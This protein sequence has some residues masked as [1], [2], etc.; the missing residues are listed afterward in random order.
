MADNKGVAAKPRVVAEKKVYVLINA[1]NVKA[2]DILS[3]VTNPG[4]GMKKMDELQKA[5]KQV[6]FVSITLPK[7]APRTPSKK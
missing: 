6:S 3:V 5:G 4:D 1:A 7:G 2:E